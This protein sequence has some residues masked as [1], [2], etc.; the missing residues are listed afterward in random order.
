MVDAFI[1]GLE[2]RKTELEQSQPNRKIEIPALQVRFPLSLN[3][4]KERG[5][6]L[7]KGQSR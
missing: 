7:L 4:N 3:P 1:T 5:L 6:I 2:A